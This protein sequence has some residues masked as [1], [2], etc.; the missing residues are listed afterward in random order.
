MVLSTPWSDG[1][2]GVLGGMPRAPITDLQFL[3]TKTLI[4]AQLVPVHVVHTNSDLN[5]GRG[6]RV[7]LAICEDESVAEGL[8]KGKGV[9]G[10]D[11]GVEDK[12]YLRLTHDDW[13]AYVDI[14]HMWKGADPTEE[15]RIRAAALEKLTPIERKVLGV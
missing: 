9:F 1:L 11:A 5:E 7:D 3:K 8:A 10:S 14:Q 12:V 6:F 2:A 4:E 13:R 15:Q